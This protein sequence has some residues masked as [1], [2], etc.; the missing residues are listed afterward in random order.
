MLEKVSPKIYYSIS[1][2]A[3]I[4]DVAPSLIRF[5]SNKFPT[6]IKPERNKKGNRLFTNKDLE[7][8]KLIH[9]LVKDLGM[10]LEGAERRIKSNASGE[11]QK[12]NVINRLNNIKKLLQQISQDVDDNIDTNDEQLF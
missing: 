11:D 5:W 12:L 1:E 6:I 10:T 7:N 9:H 4:L 2:V 8:F 3:E